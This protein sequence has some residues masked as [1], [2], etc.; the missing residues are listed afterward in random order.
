MCALLTACQ[1]LFAQDSDLY[2]DKII[3][4]LA[5]VHNIEI[6]P[7]T[8]R[9]NLEEAGLTWKMLHKLAAKRDEQCCEDWKDLIVQE[10][11]PDSSQL[12]FVDK[13]SKNELTWA[14]CFGQAP[15]GCHVELTDVFVCGD[16]YSMVAAV[17]TEGYLAADVIEGSYDS[18]LFNLFITE[19]VVCQYSFYHASAT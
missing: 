11:L 4:W 8:L 1:G 3:T 16:R 14:H 6:S 10:F 2:I 17:T 18:E 15:S 5:L 13:T 7:T 12:V 19:K 9:C